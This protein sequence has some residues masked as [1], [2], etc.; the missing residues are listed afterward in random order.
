MREPETGKEAPSEREVSGPLSTPQQSEVPVTEEITNNVNKPPAHPFAKAKDVTYSPL[1]SDNVTV[2][3]KPQ[4]VKKP[5]VIYRTSA[6]IYNPQ[7]ASD[8]YL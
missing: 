5:E 1:T 3:P 2:K 8:I 4:P 6:A 7:V